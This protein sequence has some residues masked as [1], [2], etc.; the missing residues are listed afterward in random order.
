VTRADYPVSTYAVLGLVDKV[1]DSSGYDLAAIA[2]RSLHYF[3]PVSHTLMY[4]ELKRLTDLGWVASH[5]V[6]Q[7]VAPDKSIYRI[8][9]EGRA[10]LR[11]WL[12]AEAP[13]A[14]TY[15]S[16]F[17]L[18]F[19]LAHAMRPERIAALLAQYRSA[20]RIRLDT[21][22]VVADQ[23][24]DTPRARMARLTALHGIRTLTAELDWVDEAEAELA[25]QDGPGPASAASD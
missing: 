1:P 23:L 6:E 4:R 14:T 18:R 2:D 8:T 24:K 17:L 11:E 3:W 19:F 12:H 10:A 9:P 16:A 22:Q 5:R 21:L 20:L 7:V 25:T 15:R 13:M